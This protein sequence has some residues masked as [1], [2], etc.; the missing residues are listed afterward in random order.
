MELLDILG[1]QPPLWVVL[2]I[3]LLEVISV[4]SVA[5]WILRRAL[6]P[7]SKANDA[8]TRAIRRWLGVRKIVTMSKSEHDKLGGIDKVKLN[9]GDILF[10]HE[11]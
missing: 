9:D 6:R 11:D 2:L 7:A 5:I 10:T 8:L 4:V 3:V 1:L